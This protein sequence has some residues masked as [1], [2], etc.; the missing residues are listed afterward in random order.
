MF[1]IKEEDF[2]KLIEAYEVLSDV[3]KKQNYDRFGK[4]PNGFQN[5]FNPGEA[6][7]IIEEL[8]KNVGGN[9]GGF[10]SFSGF[11]QPQPLVFQLSLN[12]EDFFNGKELNIEVESG[13]PINIKIE[14]G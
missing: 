5:N 2:K 9:F 12:L 11:N 13:S 4:S 3:N 7:D 8:F 6:S 14:P 10:R 1:R